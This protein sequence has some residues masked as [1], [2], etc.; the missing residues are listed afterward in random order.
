MIT[1]ID[2][3]II[4]VGDVVSAGTNRCSS[5]VP[6]PWKAGGSSSKS[7]KPSSQPGPIILRGG[8]FKPRSSVH[9]FQGVGSIGRDAAEE[10]LSGFEMPETPS[11]CR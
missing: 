1:I 9:S 11:R 2:R 6:A 10:A 5:P 8:I 3:R 7:P 4:R